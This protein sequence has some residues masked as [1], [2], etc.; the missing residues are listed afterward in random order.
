MHHREG[1]TQGDP[2]AM[3]M[4][5]ISIL[6]LIKN[7]KQEIADVT[8]T[9]YADDSRA[10]GKFARLNTFANTPRPGTGLSP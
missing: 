10:L 7:I 6:P 4:Y 5:G 1:V 8:H 2:L 9:W 3:I